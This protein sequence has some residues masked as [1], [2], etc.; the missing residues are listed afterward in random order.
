MRHVSLRSQLAEAEKTIKDLVSKESTVTLDCGSGS[1]PRNPFRAAMVL[2]L[3]V[4]P[5]NLPG[6]LE[7]SFGDALPVASGSISFVTAFDFLEHIPR[8]SDNPGATSTFI[9]YMN[10]IHRVL[11]PGGVLLAVSP[12]YPSEASFT[13][14][15]HV[16]PIARKTHE[17]FTGRNFAKEMGYGFTGS[18][19]KLHVSRI[20]PTHWIFNSGKQLNYF[21]QVKRVG[22]GIIYRLNHMARLSSGKTHI[23]WLFQKSLI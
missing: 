16:N 11:I 12:C 5:N 17:Y 8:V 2:H 9:G 3:D 14:P 10:E 13:D 21:G 7:V 19:E 23:V 18:F 4:V 6:F 20:R 1:N 15:T 22:A